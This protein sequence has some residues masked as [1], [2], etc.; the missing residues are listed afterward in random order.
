MFNQ[1]KMPNYQKKWAKEGD[2]DFGKSSLFIILI[3]KETGFIR[4]LDIIL[5]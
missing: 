1:S 2:E 4:K 3:Y 5:Y